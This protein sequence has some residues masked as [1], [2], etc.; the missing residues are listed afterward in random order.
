MPVS[1]KIPIIPGRGIVTS[2]STG[3]RLD[4]L[5]ENGIPTA[6]LSKVQ[7]DHKLI[8][9]N[10]ESYIGTV[11]VPVG[12]VGPL[13]FNSEIENELVY[14]AAG[15]LEGA[16]IASMNRG[17]RTIS[18]SGG[19]TAQV[20]WQKMTRVPLFQL[21]S[22]QIAE[23]FVAFID[24]NISE[25]R[26]KAESY[27]NHAKLKEL[28]T[29]SDDEFVHVK[30]VYITGDASGQNMTTTCTWHAML[31]I[32]ES[33]EEESGHQ[34][35]EYIIEGNGSSDK[36]VSQI[37]TESGRGINV[38]AECTLSE[39]T[40][41]EVLRT[42]SDKMLKVYHPS[43]RQAKKS[44][45][46]GYNINVANAIAAIFLAT[47]QDLACI[48]ESS[49]GLLELEKADD[50]LLVRL[51]LPN[52]VI[53]TVGGGTHLPKQ[54]ESLSIMNCKGN[55]K[56]E[57]F[58]K[59][60]AG[61][62]MGLEISTYAAIVSGE[63]AKAHEKLGRNK[64][65]DWLTKNELGP[66]FLK[67]CLTNFHLPVVSIELKEN[68][69][70]EN[71]I[72]THVAGRA[73]KKLIGFETLSLKYEQGG[74]LHDT[75]LLLKSKAKDTEVI[76][77]LHMLA[78]S[79]DPTLSDL[80]R[81][82]SQD[83]E[84]KNCHLK[85]TEAYTVLSS[86]KFPDIPFFYGAKDEE[87][88]EIHLVIIELLDKQSQKLFNSENSPE[89]WTGDLIRKV[90]ESAYRFHEILAGNSES[91][92][93]AN[94]DFEPWKSNDLYNKMIE[95]VSREEEDPMVTNGILSLIDASLYLKEL[96]IGISIPKTIVHN[97]FNP[98]NVA[99]SIDDEIKVYDWELSIRNYPHRDI[100]EFLSFTLQD[101]FEKEE[102]MDHLEY[103]FTIANRSGCSKEEWF[104]V[105]EFSLIELIITR[106]M[107]YEVAGIIVK[108]EFSNR[109]LKNAL[110]MLDF[111]RG[112]D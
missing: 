99:V 47:G 104:K 32:V 100:V 12:I 13:V 107:F 14:T 88:R 4:F 5:T 80:I 7:L 74:D 91:L 46:F 69:L 75:D 49:V 41:K 63:F 70:L 50:G 79:I 55:N 9:N 93:F 111:V 68:E 103:H 57:R 78:A 94:R 20:K 101:N 66:I 36:K 85:E 87:D 11:E 108:Y 76:K 35:L 10:I 30:F 26:S 31:Y 109:I 2:M 43:R 58:A 105:Y 44:G 77:G 83:L 61:F 18:L 89:M 34:V 106:I 65:V 23:E 6:E 29:F 72:L 98:R 92:P 52:L 90:I 21:P 1:E 24:R 25:I 96:S 53:A 81:M 56:V 3:L 33:F 62:A 95:I 60:I 59:L 37:S 16:L 15:T 97:D 51:T 73:T 22:A 28:I 8:Q 67:N 42:T 38:T 110:R 48:H 71:G 84:Y 17:A 27:S 54:S 40:I 86:A 82:S 112:N 102:L 45:M 39:K 64:P 19:F